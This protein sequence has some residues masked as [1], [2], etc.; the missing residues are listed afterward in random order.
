MDTSTPTINKILFGVCGVAF[1][2]PCLFFTYY[3]V[4]L[5]YLNLTMENAAAYRSAGMLIG[6]IAFPLAAM[7]FGFISWFFIKRAKRAEK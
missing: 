7:L 4:R 2:V 3:T 5:I 6:A 1:A